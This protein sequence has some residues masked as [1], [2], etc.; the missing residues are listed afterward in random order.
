MT[1]RAGL[2]EVARLHLQGLV[3]AVSKRLPDVQGAGISASAFSALE[4]ELE[5][6]LVAGVLQILGPL[7]ILAE[8]HFHVTGRAIGRAVPEQ[9]RCVL[10]PIDGSDSFRR[11]SDCYSVTLA[12]MRDDLDEYGLIYQ[13]AHDRMY[14][15]SPEEGATVDC[16][17]LVRS[18]APERRLA[19]RRTVRNDSDVDMLVRRAVTR[20][21]T[22]ERM[23]STALKLCWAAEGGRSAVVKDVGVTNGSTLS[24]GT[25]AGMMLCRAM[26][27][28]VLDLRGEPF[29]GSGRLVVCDETFRA[30]V[31]QV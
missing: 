19:V 6:A 31:L 1:R 28:N 25:S 14:A 26:G 29:R 10:D 13:P 17:P 8:E 5:A 4:W 21:Y 16:R 3:R 24:W 22:I 12:L 15:W 23:E 9:L 30:E 18:I 20:G 7:E 11:G 2:D 27:L